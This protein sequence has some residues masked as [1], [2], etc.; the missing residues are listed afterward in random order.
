MSTPKKPKSGSDPQPP[1]P[2]LSDFMRAIID[3]LKHIHDDTLSTK[4]AVEDLERE[5][6]QWSKLAPNAVLFNRVQEQARN[7][8]TAPPED[9]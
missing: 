8:K 3:W 1:D 6:R 7:P 4:Y 9:E 2:L 5:L